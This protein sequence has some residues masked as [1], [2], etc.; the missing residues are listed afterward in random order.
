MN[1]TIPARPHNGRSN[2][3]PGLVFA[4][5]VLTGLG[6]FFI[7]AVVI[8][9]FS[10]QSPRAL[11][12][13]MAVGQQAP[14]WTVV[15]AGLCLVLTLLLWR[16]I[17]NWKK[18]L[19]VLGMVLVSASAAMSRV[20]YFEWMFHPVAAPGFTSAEQAKLDAAQMVMAVRFGTD[21]RA[22]PIRAM[23]YHHVVNDVVAGVPIAVTY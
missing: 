16:R 8:R 14:L 15:I 22:Y 5:L 6:F 3:L 7:P 17:S 2:L 21:A 20:D 13:A 1:P 19:L 4:V 12:L 18:A 23:A 10:Y 11:T 9:P